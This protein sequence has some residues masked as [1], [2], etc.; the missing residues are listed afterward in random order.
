MV[1]DREIVG[2]ARVLPCTVHARRVEARVQRA[3][4]LHGEGT[5]VAHT[6]ATRGMEATPASARCADRRA[7]VARAHHGLTR[8][9]VRAV[10]DRVA[11]VDLGNTDPESVIDE[12]HE[13]GLLVAVA[14]EPCDDGALD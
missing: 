8:A 12:R 5:A 10:V 4:V 11:V 9:R 1:A 6:D 7:A 3:G 14:V 2:L 13:A